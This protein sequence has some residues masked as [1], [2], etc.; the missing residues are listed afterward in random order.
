[1][2]AK[3]GVLFA[4]H[5]QPTSLHKIRKV[6]SSF[7]LKSLEPSLYFLSR[8]FT[9]GK[10]AVGCKQT[11]F[12]VIVFNQ[13]GQVIDYWWL[14]ECHRLMVSNRVIESI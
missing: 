1:M 10:L 7:A 13:N 11:K 6:F 12:L 8:Y 2:G 14:C 9:S 3:P 5:T 4:S